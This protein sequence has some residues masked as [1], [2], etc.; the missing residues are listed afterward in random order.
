MTHKLIT[1]ARV[2]YYNG[3]KIYR[4]YDL[5]KRLRYWKIKGCNIRFYVP[6]DVFVYIDTKK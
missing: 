2:T 3:Q 5:F 6:E 4:R 1:D